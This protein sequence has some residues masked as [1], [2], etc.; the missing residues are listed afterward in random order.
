M[1]MGLEKHHLITTLVRDS[2]RTH[3]NV[4]ISGYK[5][6]EEWENCIILIDLPLKYLLITKGLGEIYMGNP[7]I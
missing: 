5:L 7:R 2:V 1:L 3:Q 4:T 6:D